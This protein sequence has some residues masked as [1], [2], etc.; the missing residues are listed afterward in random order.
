[1]SS[2]KSFDTT[3]AIQEFYQDFP[4]H[5]DDIFFVDSSNGGDYRSITREFHDRAQGAAAKNG[6]HVNWGYAHDLVRS[7]DPVTYTMAKDGDVW[8]Y[9]NKKHPLMDFVG[10]SLASR[11]GEIFSRFLLTDY[12]ARQ[13]KYIHSPDLNKKM[14]DLKFPNDPVYRNNA[15]WQANTFDHESGHALASFRNVWNTDTR[16]KDTYNTNRD[17]CFADCFALVRHYQRFGTQTGF[18]EP[19]IMDRA[20]LLPYMNHD[21]A[22][23]HLT[24][25]CLQ[26]I[27]GM[28]REK[29]ARLTPHETVSLVANVIRHHSLTPTQLAVLSRT[30]NGGNGALHEDGFGGLIAYYAHAALNEK[31]PW[32]RPLVNSY[33]D[34]VRAFYSL[35]RGAASELNAASAALKAARKIPA[36]AGFRQTAQTYLQPAMS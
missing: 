25:A 33:F 29:L 5:K 14:P 34:S 15:Y 23:Q 18:T 36:N 2:S 28:G 19:C 9:S 1:M 30:A 21:Y 7:Q 26:E 10:M 4:E 3:K 12:F 8:S 32:L 6:A 35:D 17:E 11:H 31:E 20:R 27:A 16:N 22:Y 13:N 24:L